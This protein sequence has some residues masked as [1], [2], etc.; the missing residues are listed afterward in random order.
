MVRVFCVLA[1]APTA[2]HRPAAAFQVD[3]FGPRC[4]TTEATVRGAIAILG[5]WCGEF[6]VP[7]SGE[8]NS[9]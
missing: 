4:D 9:L 8:V 6:E 1:E 2:V 3:R 7:I 5:D